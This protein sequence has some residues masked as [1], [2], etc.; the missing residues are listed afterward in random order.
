MNPLNDTYQLGRIKLEGN[1][2]GWDPKNEDPLSS[3]T[4]MLCAI[5]AE[6]F[7]VR[8]LIYSIL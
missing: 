2:S 3:E 1:A 5:D 7:V 8:I 4:T 6:E